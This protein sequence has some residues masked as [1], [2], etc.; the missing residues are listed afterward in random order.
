M[1]GTPCWA[2]V[3]G[4]YLAGS[5]SHLANPLSYFWSRH[6]GAICLASSRFYL[7]HAGPMPVPDGLPSR[8]GAFEGS[9]AA[10]A[11]RHV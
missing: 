5:V 11:A 1:T 6:C 2:P 3:T 4:H 7:L 9:G 10:G 8:D